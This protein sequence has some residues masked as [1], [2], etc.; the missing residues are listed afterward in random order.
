[1][2]GHYEHG[3]PF[4]IEDDVA[5]L[6]DRTSFAGSMATFDRLVR[7]MLRMAR[8]PLADV[9]TMA[10]RT[11]ARIMGFADRSE[12]ASGMRAY[13]TF[14]KED[15]RVSRTMVAGRTVYLKG[16]GEA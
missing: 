9:I 8:A 15:I 14:F 6:P 3:L 10:A 13:L 1:M 4:I 16:D 12:I 5:E 2:L 11:P 7:N